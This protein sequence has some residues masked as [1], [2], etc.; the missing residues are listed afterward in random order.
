M[1]E[2]GPRVKTPVM[3]L[4]PLLQFTVASKNLFYSSMQRTPAPSPADT[5]VP[6]VPMPSLA[7][8][9]QRN[10]DES[11]TTA[12]ALIPYLLALQ[13]DVGRPVLPSAGS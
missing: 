6:G 1:L 4:A 11:T 7:L 12:T 2:E 13:F 9:H 3:S 8:E 5:A 10:R